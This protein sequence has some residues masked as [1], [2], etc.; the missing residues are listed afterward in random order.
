MGLMAR[1]G[2]EVEDVHYIQL[3]LKAP[4]TQSGLFHLLASHGSD[5]PPNSSEQAVETS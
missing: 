3:G 2:A 5:L 1:A 4:L